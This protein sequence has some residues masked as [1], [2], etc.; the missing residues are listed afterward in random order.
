MI[1]FF[2]F[3]LLFLILF[4]L[5]TV[6][7]F[8]NENLTPDFFEKLCLSVGR[9]KLNTTLAIRT[10]YGSDESSHEY[11]YYNTLCKFLYFIVTLEL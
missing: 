2:P 11:V 1:S 10:Q 6:F 7:Y 8:Q 9:E 4:Q 5:I 3:I